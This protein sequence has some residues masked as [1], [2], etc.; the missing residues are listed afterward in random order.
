MKVRSMIPLKSQIVS[1]NLNGTVRMAFAWC[2]EAL[3]LAFMIML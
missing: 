1:H 3:P 2:S